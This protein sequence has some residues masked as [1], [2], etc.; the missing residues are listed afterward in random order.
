MLFTA[1]PFYLLGLYASNPSFPTDTRGLFR[2]SL[3]LPSLTGS[4]VVLFGSRG[5]SFCVCKSAAPEQNVCWCQIS[6]LSWPP[7]RG[8]MNV[9]CLCDGCCLCWDFQTESK[10]TKRSVNCQRR[11]RAVFLQQGVS[12]VMDQG[13]F[14]L[15]LSKPVYSCVNLRKPGINAACS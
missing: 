5:H 6:S 9:V 8:G 10:A 4:F 7:I 12:L 2:T 13:G 3:W 14:G 11:G 15:A 1:L